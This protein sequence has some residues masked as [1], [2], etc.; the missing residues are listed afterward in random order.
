MKHRS[1]ILAGAVCLLSGCA[2]QYQGLRAGKAALGNTEVPSFGA[3]RY[4][5]RFTL[6]N[7]KTKQPWGNHPF[8]L[9][10]KQHDLPS[11]QPSKSVYHGV[12]DAHGN[13]PIFRMNYR[14]PDTQ[15]DVTER[16]G[17]GAFGKSFHIGTPGLLSKPQ[18]GYPYAMVMCLPS[19]IVHF[20]VTDARG[21]T[22]YLASD[23]EGEIA[24]MTGGTP[25]DREGLINDACK[26][27]Q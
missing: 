14:I 20:G 17:E 7:P 10:A 5:Y 12:T 24:L 3:G 6:I 25:G 23:V 11:R 9:F 22:A 19:P 18:A 16:V 4:A 21:N 1:L 13:T 8:R 2:V 26:K 15:W 27:P